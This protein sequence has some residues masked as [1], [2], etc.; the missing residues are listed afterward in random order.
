MQADARAQVEVDFGADRIRLRRQAIANVRG[1][2]AVAGGE[3]VVER[4]AG[5]VE[6]G[7]AGVDA[8]D[9]LDLAVHEANRRGQ[10]GGAAVV[11]VLHADAHE[12]VVEF[13][14]DVAANLATVFGALGAR[15]AAVAGAVEAAHREAGFRGE[16]PADAHVDSGQV[17]AE[18]LGQRDAA[19]V[20]LA[21]LADVV[22]DAAGRAG[23]TRG[24]RAA[25]QHFEAVEAVVDAYPRVGRG[26]GDVTELQ[27][28]QA[29]FLELDVAG[30]ASRDGNA[31]N[32]DVRV[33]LAT[34]RLRAQA[35][36]GTQHFRRAGRSGRDHAIA[37]QGADGQA[38]VHLR[39]AGRRAR[40]DHAVELQAIG[41]IGGRRCGLRV[42]AAHLQCG[43]S[44]REGNAARDQVAVHA[45]SLQRCSGD[46]GQ[47]PLLALHPVMRVAPARP[48]SVF[49]L[50]AWAQL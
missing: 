19:A 34:A 43:E 48:N 49:R 25:A 14:G 40:H 17:V 37:R 50:G 7:G 45:S 3:R 42:G 2:A 5:V 46:A 30:A 32:A 4:E 10:V 20:F 44:C 24:S 13:L 31:A 26:E 33:A 23:G 15:A 6:R 47:A 21:G 39:A 27:D 9:A 38:R 41:R 8:V 28:R 35:R 18:A 36:N 29:V 22:D 12:A 16:A 1:G 11:E